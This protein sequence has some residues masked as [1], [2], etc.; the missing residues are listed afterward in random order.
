LTIEGHDNSPLDLYADA[1]IDNW[2]S[3]AILRPSAVSTV[4]GFSGTYPLLTA[5]QT[6][7]VTS[8]QAVTGRAVY[9]PQRN[10]RHTF[11]L[12][13]KNL[14]LLNAPRGYVAVNNPVSM[15]VS[16]LQGEGFF[17]DGTINAGNTECG[18]LIGKTSGSDINGYI[19]NVDTLYVTGS[20]YDSAIGICDSDGG[21]AK[22]AMT[23][24]NIN[25]KYNNDYRSH[26]LTYTS[27]NNGS[28]GFQQAETTAQWKNF[29]TTRLTISGSTYDI[30]PGGPSSRLQD[31]GGKVGLIERFF[32]GRIPRTGNSET[33]CG[34]FISGVEVDGSGAQFAQGRVRVFA[35]RLDTGA[36]DYG[37]FIV[38]QGLSSGGTTAS[39]TSAS[40]QKV[41]TIASS[42]LYGSGTVLTVGGNPY[43]VTSKVGNALTLGR[44]LVTTVNN[45]DAVTHNFS[46]DATI[47]ALSGGIVSFTVNSGQSRIDITNLLG[48]SIPV[49]FRVHVESFGVTAP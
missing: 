5:P 44:N 49:E 28:D 10:G 19:S 41:L 45:G 35:R 13:I 33:V 11:G 43:V 31:C 17:Q 4:A 6:A 48:S 7:L 21:G 27:L 22:S 18:V 1:A 39:G 26:F 2:L 9:I 8:F 24:H 14:L 38:T 40:G 12:T 20:N 25:G 32:G 29:F 16:N 42:A 34:I 15:H 37:E 46:L 30:A 36:Q 3:Q 47:R 23:A